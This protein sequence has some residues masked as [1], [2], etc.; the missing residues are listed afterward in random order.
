MADTADIVVLGA[1][2]L[3]ASVAYH[4]CTL[5]AGDVIVAERD[6]RV[7]RGATGDGL[8]VIRSLFASEVNVRLSAL[9]TEK[10]L[11]FREEVGGSLA[12]A[13]IGYLCVARNADELDRAK[14]AMT[15]S[16]AAGQT[17]ITEV[18]TKEIAE[19]HPAVLTDD[20]IGGVFSPTDGVLDHAAVTRSYL[21]A[22]STRGAVL[23]LRAGEAVPIVTNGRVTGVR[24]ERGLISTGTAVIAC[25]MW[26]A[27]VAGPLGIVAPIV[28]ERHRVAVTLPFDGVPL[29]TPVTRD[30]GSGFEGHANGGRVYLDDATIEPVDDPADKALDAAWLDRVTAAAT[31]RLP[32]LRHT[33]IDRPACRAGVNATTPDGHMLLGPHPTIRGLYFATA[34]GRHGFMHAPAIGLV[35]AEMIVHGEARAADVESLR[36]SRFEESAPIEAALL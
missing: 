26:S 36:P 3:G 7:G 4:L 8:G 25:G 23:R 11:H 27:Q 34:A 20:L 30:L 9:S 13:P 10:Y 12:F 28:G 22:A 32:I 24:T 2:A 17:M 29:G 14:R 21:Q 33:S 5:S 16:R 1:G 15:I 35:T 19:I 6:E 18:G 31:A